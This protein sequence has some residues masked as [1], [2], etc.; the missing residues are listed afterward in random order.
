MPHVHH[1][2]LSH[3]H[4]GFHQ[5]HCSLARSLACLPLRAA[6]AKAWIRNGTAQNTPHVGMSI[7]P[8]RDPSIFIYFGACRQGFNVELRGAPG[9]TSRCSEV[10]AFLFGMF[11]VVVSEKFDAELKFFSFFEVLMSFGGGGLRLSE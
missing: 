7:E 5:R 9:L 4:L 1:T 11:V 10:L 2:Y 6:I 3:G 8:C